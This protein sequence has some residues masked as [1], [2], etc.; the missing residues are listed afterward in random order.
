M[1]WAGNSDRAVVDV[2]II[3]Y[4]HP[5]WLEEAVDS[6]VNQQFR[7]PFNIYIYDDKSTKRQQ[8]MQ[9][10]N[11]VVDAHEDPAILIARELIAAQMPLSKVVQELVSK[12]SIPY[13]QAQNVVNLAN[14]G[15]GTFSTPQ[16]QGALIKSDSPRQ[17]LWR[18][19]DAGHSVDISRENRGVS[20]A[21][22]HIVAAEGGAPWILFLD[23]D[24]KLDEHFLERAWRRANIVKAEVIYPK[25]A[26]FVDGPGLAPHGSLNQGEFDLLRLLRSN[27]I[28]VTSLMKRSA[29]D[30]TDGFDES[31]KHGFEDWCLWIDMALHDRVFQ[32]E[33]NA[34]LYYRHHTSARSNE[35]NRRLQEIYGYIKGKYKDKFETLLRPRVEWLD[36][37][38]PVE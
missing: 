29:F 16:A 37:L 9:G 34:V 10:G 30:D 7:Q 14:P 35:A 15:R 26:I 4:N 22:N 33:P 36:D 13:V 32:F 19:R 38:E 31:M 3:T 18:L 28:P 8:I 23:G 6:V 17:V 12:F 27:Y 5:A 21:R 1:S 25:A 11:Y 24:D 20:A 2:Y